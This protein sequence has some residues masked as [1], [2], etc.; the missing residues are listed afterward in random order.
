MSE[1][2]IATLDGHHCLVIKHA[3]SD[4]TKAILAHVQIGK[5]FDCPEC[6]VWHEYDGKQWSNVK[7]EELTDEDTDEPFTRLVCDGCEGGFSPPTRE[8]TFHVSGQATLHI[9]C[10]GLPDNITNGE[11]KPMTLVCTGNRHLEGQYMLEYWNN[12][13]GTAKLVGSPTGKTDV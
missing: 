4:T 10:M 8:E 9:T 11:L 6:G 12:R 2:L 1:H 7:E 13:S 5:P 3:I